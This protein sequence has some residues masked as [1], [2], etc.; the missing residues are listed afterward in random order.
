[1]KQR[2]EQE[3]QHIFSSWKMQDG[4]LVWKRQT[5]RGKN[6]GDPVGLTI[7]NS[8]H[9][10]CFLQI[11]KKLIGFSVGQIAWFLHHGV[12][13]DKEVDHIDCNPQ[14]NKKDNL[15]LSDRSEQTKN[16]VS[17][18]AGRANKGVYVDKRTGK[19]YAQIWI[20]G[21]C[22]YLGIFNN[23]EEAVEVRMLAN[24]M[25]HGDFANNMSYGFAKE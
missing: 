16:R 23:L 20:K 22:K 1:M 5:K 13:A 10:L 24:E 4:V 21:N 18:K 17:G 6:I 15:R 12:W 14:N 25:L 2:T 3:L 11:N 7:K 8:G 9:M 19:F